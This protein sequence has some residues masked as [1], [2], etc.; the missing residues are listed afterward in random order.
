MRMLRQQVKRRLAFPLR[1]AIRQLVDEIKIAR[2]HRRSCR[3]A[4]QLFDGRIIR[5]NL[6]SGYRPKEG[7][8]NVDL[9]APTADLRVDLR[10]QFPFADGSVSEIYVEHFFEHLDYP[11]IYESM[12]WVLEAPDCPSDVKSFL[13]ECWRVLTPG[14]VLDLLVPD[15]E[16]MIGVYVARHDA[17]VDPADWWGPQW[18][19]TPMHRVNYLFRQGREHRYAYDEE[20]LRR[21]LEA[22][23]FVEVRRRPFN[24]ASD[25]ADHA[26]GS[27]CMLASKPA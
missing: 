14:G 15:A 7:W 9:F 19:D 5:L 27:L 18:C 23:M 13:H 4:K 25:A 10:R 17:P 21:V 26:I 2:L 20:T 12:G 1:L 11:N 16:G 24:A 22:S 8:V 3:A 6:A